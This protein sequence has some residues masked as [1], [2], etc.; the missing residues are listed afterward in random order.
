[1]KTTTKHKYLDSNTNNNRCH[2]LDSVSCQ[3]SWGGHLFVSY[4]LFN[5]CSMIN[6]SN[7][8]N[9]IKIISSVFVI[10]FFALWSL[11]NTKRWNSFSEFWTFGAEKRQTKKS[12]FFSHLILIKVTY[13]VVVM[14]NFK[15]QVLALLVVLCNISENFKHVILFEVISWRLI[16]YL[17]SIKIKLWLPVV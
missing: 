4:H 12:L 1:M 2:N 3:V 7:S 10:V 15:G 8:N 6:L 13:F 16:R 14:L 5:H 11:N 9:H 17:P